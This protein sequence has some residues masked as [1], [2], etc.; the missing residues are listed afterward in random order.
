ME[1]NKFYTFCV[2]T[3]FIFKIDNAH[4]WWENFHL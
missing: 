1:R 2:L 3:P 4:S